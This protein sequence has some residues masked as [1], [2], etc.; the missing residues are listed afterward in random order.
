MQSY[1]PTNL[2][3]TVLQTP[4]PKKMQINLTGFLTASTPMFMTALWSLLLDAQDSPA[5]IPRGFEEEKD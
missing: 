2:E 3:L 4:D 1:S 5:G